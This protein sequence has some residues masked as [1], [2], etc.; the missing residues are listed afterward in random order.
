[1]LRVTRVACVALVIGMAACGD[2]DGGDGMAD[3]DGDGDDGGDDGG[4]D[5]GGDGPGEPAEGQFEL[6]ES[7][8]G[9]GG[10]AWSQMRGSI[11][12]P[13]PVYHRLEQ[14]AGAC[15]LWTY[16]ELAVVCA[17]ARRH[18]LEIEAIENFDPAHWYDVL[19][20]GPKKAEQLQLTV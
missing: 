5:G 15:Q 20:D 18:G 13:R 2:D 14:E 8:F 6:R 17:D 3:D 10:Q 19:L 9:E 12:D 1:M 4:G 16:E 7:E 11:V